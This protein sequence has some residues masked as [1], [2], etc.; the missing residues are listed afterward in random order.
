[1]FQPWLQLPTELKLKVLQHALAQADPIAHSAH[2]DNVRVRH[3]SPL[4]S[5][6]N[7]ELSQ[8]AIDA[9][10]KSNTFLI[11]PHILR[12]T[13]GPRCRLIRP[14]AQ[15]APK[16][17]H[18]VFRT[19]TCFPRETLSQ[20]VSHYQYDELANILNRQI[21]PWAFMLTLIEHKEGEVPNDAVRAGW[22]RDFVSLRT[23]TLDLRLAGEYAM[24]EPDVWTRFGAR[25]DP[26]FSACTCYSQNDL[27][28][29]LAGGTTGINA[30]KVLV[31]ATVKGC[32]SGTCELR[33]V[34]ALQAVLS[35]DRTD[36]SA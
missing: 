4:I 5:T 21:Y 2:L 16:I 10:Y 24:D 8:L 33:L 14:H 18:L 9:Y 26:V 17:Q 36:L 1:M 28:E 13:F 30:K 35:G 32:R 29:V 12:T 6:R 7:K 3:L 23:F 20:A 27:I 11:A 19:A 31:T 34:G 25:Q 15:L 22:Q